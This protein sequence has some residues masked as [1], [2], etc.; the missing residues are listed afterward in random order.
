[1]TTGNRSARNPEYVPGYV[2]LA[3]RLGALRSSDG[4]PSPNAEIAS[5]QLIILRMRN[6]TPLSACG[7]TVVVAKLRIGRAIVTMIPQSDVAIICTIDKWR[8]T[9]GPPRQS[10][11]RPARLDERSSFG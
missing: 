5:A 2:M 7:L 6:E 11:A 8:L 4:E 9:H 10:C 3:P 1:V